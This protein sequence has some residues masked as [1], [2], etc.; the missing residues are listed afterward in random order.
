MLQYFHLCH[1]IVLNNNSHFL[2]DAIESDQKCFKITMR[3]KKYLSFNITNMQH[4][5]ICYSMNDSL[6]CHEQALS[7]NFSMI[8][9]Y[10]RTE[11]LYNFL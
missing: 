2:S 5:L 4:K 11:L 10:F 1:I 8:H 7:I 6:T 9:V 3:A